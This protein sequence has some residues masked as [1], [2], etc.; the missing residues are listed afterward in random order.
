MDYYFECPKC[1]SRKEF[2]SVHGQG[3]ND[4]ALLLFGGLF[5]W[6]MFRSSSGRRVQCAACGYIFPQPS[7]PNTSGETLGITILLVLGAA[8][9]LTTLAIGTP[10]LENLLPKNEF[11]SNLEEIIQNHPRSILLGLTVLLPLTGAV[12]ILGMMISTIAGKNRLRRYHKT[13]PAPFPGTMNTAPTENTTAG[14]YSGY[15]E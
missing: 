4:T 11:F 3:G 9:G 10:E 5:L 15:D 6:L 1:C 12:T 13:R 2:F 14:D 8:M 7:R